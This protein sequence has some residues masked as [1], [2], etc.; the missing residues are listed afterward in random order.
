M[1]VFEVMTPEGWEWVMPKSGEDI[2]MIV[3]AFG[4]PLAPAW[5]P[6]E[7]ELLDVEESGAPSEPRDSTESPRNETVGRSR[8]AHRRSMCSRARHPMALVA[9]P[10]SPSLCPVLPRAPR[11]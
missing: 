11:V 3:E 7:V 9:S 1:R 6:V 8:G 2:L 4:K 5:S 10:A